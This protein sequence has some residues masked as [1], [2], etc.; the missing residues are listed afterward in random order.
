MRGRPGQTGIGGWIFLMFILFA[1]GG[2]SVMM[3][4]FLILAVVIGVTVASVQ[5]SKKMDESGSRS[6]RGTYRRMNKDTT[7]AEKIARIN[8]FMRKWFRNHDTYSL[9]GSISLKLKSDNYA[10]LASLDVY[11]DNRYLCSMNDFERRYPESYAQVIAELFAA[12]SA[13]EK[14]D[15]ID[16]NVT[17]TPEKK[18]EP[19]KQE[20]ETV[21]TAQGYINTINSL[22]QSIPDEE[23]TNG[24][25]ETCALLKQI[26][27]LEEKLPDSKSK[28]SKLFEYYLP[29]LTRILKQFVTLQDAKT[30]PAYEETKKK[31]GRT[32]SLIN[33]AMKKIISSMTDQDFINL[34]ADI[35]T[36]EAVLK[37][38]GLTEDGQMPSSGE[39]K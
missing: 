11:R 21:R 22:N 17:D 15:V 32:I 28:L 14:D 20:E 6:R 8:M 23:I 24:L 38:D 34:S 29:I 39:S 2:G 18:E 13:P 4:L 31:L 3:P 9:T 27:S 10:S 7:S 30:D 19:K 1:F 12:A 37:K 25:Y 5:S 35:S 26:D 36:L 33:D 16:V